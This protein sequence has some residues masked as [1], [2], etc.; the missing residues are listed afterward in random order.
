[1][2]VGTLLLR[3]LLEFN[4]NV[5]DNEDAANFQN[6]GGITFNAYS[7]TSSDGTAIE[8][9]EASLTENSVGTNNLEKQAKYRSYSR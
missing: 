9:I 2:V 5:I 3:D 6:S 1:M 7:G 8:N 4:D